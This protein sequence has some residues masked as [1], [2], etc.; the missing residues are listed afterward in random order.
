MKSL[1]QKAAKVAKIQVLRF[2]RCL[3]F[4][5]FGRVDRPLVS[6][7]I[8]HEETEMEIDKVK[9][10]RLEIAVSADSSPRA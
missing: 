6:K 4:K 7:A 5:Q 1:K 9:Y 10:R 3:L 8:E 2:L